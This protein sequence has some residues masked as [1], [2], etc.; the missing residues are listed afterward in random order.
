MPAA[1]AINSKKGDKLPSALLLENSKELIL[2][3]WGEAYV[4]EP[5]FSERFLIEAEAAL[6]LVTP[7]S[8]LDEIFAAMQHQRAKLKA[9]QQLAEW[10]LT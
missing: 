2:D 7:Q 3:W 4:S 9:S 8:G 10:S 5:K 6:P 1:E